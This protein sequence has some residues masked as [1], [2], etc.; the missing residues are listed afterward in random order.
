[1]CARGRPL[2]PI[3]WTHRPTMDPPRPEPAKNPTRKRSK[4][5]ARDGAPPALEVHRLSRFAPGCHRFFDSQAPMIVSQAARPTHRWPRLGPTRNL[6]QP[7]SK[8]DYCSR[9]LHAPFLPWF[10]TGLFEFLRVCRGVLA[11]LHAS[12]RNFPCATPIASPQAAECALR[13]PR[14][15]GRASC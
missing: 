3:F 13:R 7:A 1:M 10:T 6:R 11:S 14:R 9:T 5:P 12:L 15:K 2:R 4:S 8:G